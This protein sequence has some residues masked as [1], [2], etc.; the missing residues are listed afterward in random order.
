MS[1]KG[2]EYHVVVRHLKDAKGEP[3]SHEEPIEFSAINHDD[4]FVNLSLLRQADLMDE[5]TLKQFVV[6]LKL[7]MEVMMH[8]REIPLFKEFFPQMLKFM[9]ELKSTIPP[10]VM[11]AAKAAKAS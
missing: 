7:F 4:F 8:N 5:E 3:S 1:I 10:E 2:H 9:K 6:G 11:A